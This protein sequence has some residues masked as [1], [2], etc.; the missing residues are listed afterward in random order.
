VLINKSA[1]V[2]PSFKSKERE[3]SLIK[4]NVEAQMLARIEANR[5]NVL[6]KELQPSSRNPLLEIEGALESNTL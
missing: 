3:G 6:N 5:H 4:L 1:L 2:G